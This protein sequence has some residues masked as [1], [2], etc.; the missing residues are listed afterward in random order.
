MKSS[1]MVWSCVRNLGL[2]FCI[3]A[4]ASGVCL[5]R[6]HAGSFADVK[7]LILMR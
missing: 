6:W 1:R 5:G 3:T 2:P 4:I 7:K